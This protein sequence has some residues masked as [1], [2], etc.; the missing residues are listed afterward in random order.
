MNSKKSANI[1]IIGLQWGDEGKGKIVDFLSDKVDAVVRFQGGHNAGHTIKVDDKTYKLSLLPSGIIRAKFC[2]IGSGVVVDPLALFAE[3]EKIENLGIKIN[4]SNL[5]IADNCCLILSIHR[6]LDCFLEEKKGD[7]K[8]GTT[9]RGIGPAYEDRAGRRALRICDLI[10][11]NILHQR[12]ENLLFYHNLL[13]KSLGASIVKIDQIIAEIK[14]IQ[15]RLLY[16]ARPAFEIAKKLKSSCKNIMFEG[17]QGALLDVTYGTFPFVT[18]SNIMS[19]QVALGSC[20]GVADIHN[21]IGILKAYTTRVG[22]GPFPTELHDETGKFLRIEGKEIGT[23]TGR[24]RRCG[25]FDSVLVRQA[26]QLSSVKEIALTKLDVLDKLEKIK[27]CVA[28]KIAG[29]TYDYL[30]Q[31]NHLWEKI[32]PVYEEIDGWQQS[33]VGV[34]SVEELPTKALNY[35]RKIEELCA[36][37]AVIISTGAKREETIILKDLV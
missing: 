15:E 1:A 7:R 12:L 32:E 25:W 10:D 37:K 26:I 20:L 29:T 36:V 28:Y 2:V 35:I 5:A 16:F 19:G 9:G 8:I 11:E 31:A 4:S 24:D 34:K 13:R 21:T 14:P 17:A 30:P 18:S 6:E 23:V 27:I 22:S 3:I 33:T